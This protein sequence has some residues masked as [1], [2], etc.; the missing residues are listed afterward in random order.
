MQSLTHGYWPLEQDSSSFLALLKLFTQSIWA[1]SAVLL[2]Q[3]VHIVCVAHFVLHRH[4][5][6]DARAIVHEGIKEIVYKQHLLLYW[7][8]IFQRL[9]GLRWVKYIILCNAGS[10]V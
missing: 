9:L 4:E 5:L 6:Q 3:C 2:R 8:Y 10:E 1:A 7:M